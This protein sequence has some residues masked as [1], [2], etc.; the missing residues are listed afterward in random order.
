[1]RISAMACTFARP[2]SLMS[3]KSQTRDPSLKSL[4][5]DLCSVVLRPE[6]IH[7]PQPGLNPRILDLEENTSPRD[8]R[9]RLGS[10][11][12]AMEKF[13]MK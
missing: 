5:K 8:H 12:I 2:D 13:R 10:V 4:P 3:Q 6:K 11:V 9:G 7:R 1:M